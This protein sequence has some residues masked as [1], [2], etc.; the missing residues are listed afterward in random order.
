[1]LLRYSPKGALGETLLWS[2]HFAPMA[3][4]DVLDDGRVELALRGSRLFA[5]FDSVGRLIE[6]DTVSN[7]IVRTVDTALVVMSARN[8]LGA[9]AAE[10]RTWSFDTDGQ[11]I[12]EVSATYAKEPAKGTGV[13]KQLSLFRLGDESRTL[14]INPNLESKGQFLATLDHE[15]FAALEYGPIENKLLF[16]TLSPFGSPDAARR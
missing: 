13:T 2:D 8:R 12:I 16:L 9:R 11:I 14:V 6:F 4:D 5:L 7:R 1:V 10:I 15:R 3:I